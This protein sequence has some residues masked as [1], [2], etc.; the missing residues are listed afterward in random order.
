VDV[1]DQVRARVGA[2]E[3]L[4]EVVRPISSRVGA[5]TAADCYVDLSPPTPR[6]ASEPA[7]G[8]RGRGSGRPT[9]RERRDID[10]LRGRDR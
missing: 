5:P 1:G 10:R 3:R 9:K 2:R 7:S 6:E 4:I 8:R